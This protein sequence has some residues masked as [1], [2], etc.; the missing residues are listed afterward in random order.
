MK[1]SIVR[2]DNYR[3]AS[4]ESHTPEPVVR[5]TAMPFE[6]LKVGELAKRTGLTVRA[7]HHYDEVGLLRPSLRTEA[8]HRLYAAADVARLQ[9]VMSLRQ[10]GFSLDEIRDCLDRKGFS[11]LEVLR[12]H[13]ARLREQ[14]QFQSALC[15]RLEAIAVRLESAGEV[16]ADDFLHAMEAMT[17]I[18]SYYT[19]EQ[20]EQL[21]KRREEVGEERIA[22]AP[23]DWE[24][25]TAE[26]RAAKEK[27]LDPADPRVQ[28]LARRW[29][30][31]IDEFTGGD[32]G[33]AQSLAKLWKEQGANLAAQ[34]GS[35]HDPSLAEYIGKALKA[36]KGL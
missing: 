22:Q 26:V 10:L 8:G 32:P 20:L 12:W 31:L 16:S 21:K 27:G 28:A 2:F 17:V 19:P 35:V 9:R 7:L 15:E 25:L 23:S 4:P 1:K 29:Q 3:P 30:G 14:I 24:A 33:I 6:A 11:P 36:A 13:A 5:S 18:E 34:Y